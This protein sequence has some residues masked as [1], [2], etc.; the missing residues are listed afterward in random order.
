MRPFD[1]YQQTPLH[2][3]LQVVTRTFAIGT[4][5]G[6][7]VRMYWAAAILMPLLFLSWVAPATATRTEAFVLAALMFVLLFVVIWTHEMGHVLG[8]RRFG[9]RTDLI[10]LSPMGGLA[11]MGAPASSP[12]EELWTTLAGPVTHLAWLAVFWP[13]SLVLS[14]DALAVSGWAWSPLWFAVWYLVT[15]NTWLLLFN[16]LPVVPL[17]GGRVLRA[18]LSLRVHP[19][20]ATRWATTIGIGG[21]AVMVAWGLFEARIASTIL[22][23]IGLTCIMGSLNERRM[24]Q[25]VLVYQQ[26]ARRMPWEVDGDAWK[27][28]GDPQQARPGRF[29]R[30]R[31]ARARKRAEAKAT[32]DAALEREVDAIL[33]RVHQVGMSGLSDREKAVLRKASARRRDTG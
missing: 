25:H 20:L 28:G 30:W 24:A 14:A 31:E 17:D 21:G 5:S 10:T 19:N 32:R 2:R 11:H 33:E 3:V 26:H 4:F 18:L 8:G 27:H 15:L 22:V 12:R 16:L 6:T 13:L 1:P 9:I 23:V 7:H 29:A